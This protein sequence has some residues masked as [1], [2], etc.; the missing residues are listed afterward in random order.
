MRFT[1]LLKEKYFKSIELFGEPVEI[2]VNLSKIELNDIMYKNSYGSV[3]LGVSDKPRPK[4]YAWDAGFL[5]SE[6]KGKAPTI[7]FDVGFTYTK[8]NSEFIE[9]YGMDM[10]QWNKVK[11]KEKIL[12][13]IKKM[14]PK[15]NIMSMKNGTIDI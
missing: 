14:F 4:I 13:I 3:R 11:N 9:I 6:I 7:K 2:F 15:V 1:E 5:H 8:L 10:K 12:G